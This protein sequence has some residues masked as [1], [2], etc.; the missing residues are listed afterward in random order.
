MGSKLCTEMGVRFLRLALFVISFG[1]NCRPQCY[2][3]INIQC[4]EMP[5]SP[6]FLFPPP[7]SE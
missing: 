2:A 7:T 1:S 5:E 6:V 4:E 3:C